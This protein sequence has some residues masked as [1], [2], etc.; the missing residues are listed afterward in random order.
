LSETTILGPADPDFPTGTGIDLA[1]LDCLRAREYARLDE[2]SHV[3]LDYTGAG[4]H[5]SSQVREHTAVLERCLLG[6]PHSTNPTSNAAS[7]FS[8]RARE[9]VLEFFHASPDDYTV[10]F[11]ANATGA[12]KLVGEAYPFDADSR[13]ALTVDNHNS[14]NGIREFARARSTPVTYVPVVG[15]E[16]RV[17][18]DRLRAALD[19]ITPG[20]NS[21]FAYPAQ[22]NLS[23]AQ[24]PL[25]WIAE[26]RQRGWDLLLDA[27]A[28]APTNRLD[29]DRWQPDFV[30]LS[31]YKLFGYPTGIGCLIARRSALA[32]LRRPW[33]SGGTID[34]ASVGL[35]AHEMHADETAFEDGTINFLGLPAVEIGLR[36]LASLDIDVVHQRVQALTGWLLRHMAAL[37]YANGVPVVRLYGPTAAE[38]R[39]GTVAFNVLT[40]DGEVVDYRLVENAA[41]EWNISLRGGCFCNPGASEAALGLTPEMLTAVFECD[42][43]SAE[44][45][46]RRHQWGMVRASL[47]VASTPAD[48]RRFIEFLMSGEVT[49]PRA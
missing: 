40:S 27:S 24:H 33:F 49:L 31:F 44:G 5:A 45:S 26:A 10:V 19:R 3:Y 6:N 25:E 15:P 42:R 37:R 41:G 35:D 38:G 23:G 39:G 28:F 34:I 2:Q 7:E 32:R 9:R 21:L 14:V 29:V 22:S 8:R 47:G 17:D 11:T 13:L 48:I 4:L 16:L 46:R 36:Y 20:S 12:L 18:A 30:C 43:N 1:A